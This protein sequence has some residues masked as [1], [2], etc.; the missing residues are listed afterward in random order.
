[1]SPVKLPQLD[2]LRGIC[3]L[4]VVFYHIMFQ[5]PGYELGILRNA[6]LFVDFFFVLS[7]FIMFHNYSGLSTWPGFR[8][9]IALR[10]FRTYPL[11]VVMLAVFLGYEILQYALVTLYDL[12]T[13]TAPFTNN[14]ATTLLLNVLLLNG[15]GIADLSFNTP[16]WSISTEFW[17]YVIFGLGMLLVTRQRGQLLLFATLSIGSL[18]FLATRHDP[19]L[20]A[21]WQRFLPRCLHGFFLGATLRGV[22][23]I[24]RDGVGSPFFASLLQ[25]LSVGLAVA[26]VSVAQGAWLWLELVIP[27]AF[28]AVIAS[29]VLWPRTAI[30]R[31]FTN[32]PLLWLGKISY[33]IYMVHLIVVQLL[34][35]FMRL[36]L[37]APIHDETLMV[38]DTVGSFAVVLALTLV[39]GI[40]AASY[41][42]IE[43]PARRAGRNWL[44]ATRLSTREVPSEPTPIAC[45]SLS[46]PTTRS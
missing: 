15:V 46:E 6:A 43:E 20:T 41:R 45:S 9:F 32:A 39:L 19:S 3:A 22:M 30:V 33:S 13:S 14:N 44:N 17:A 25:S 42:F 18:A 10:F 8:R 31:A 16:A 29:F 7:G 34:Q 5:H 2:V 26:L 38:G 24:E 27:L 21:H 35:A 23:L 40:A 37:K 28:S 12:P 4:L 11:H 36:V 1:M